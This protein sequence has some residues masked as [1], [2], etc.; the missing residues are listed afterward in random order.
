M[1]SRIYQLEFWGDRVISKL[2]FQ[3][4]YSFNINGPQRIAGAEHLGGEVD[5]DHPWPVTFWFGAW[6]G[7]LLTGYMQGTLGIPFQPAPAP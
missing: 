2:G 6:D 5:Y 1:R 4:T 3:L 7:D